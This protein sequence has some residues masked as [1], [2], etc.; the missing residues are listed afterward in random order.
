MTILARIYREPAALLAL[1]T[2]VLAVLTGSGALTTTG[3]AIALGVITAAL[4]ALRYVVTPSAEVVVQR[5]PDAGTAVAGPASHLADG[6]PV[7]V[8]PLVD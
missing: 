3:A 7:W 1:A 4:G 6:T 5:K 8:R 2:A